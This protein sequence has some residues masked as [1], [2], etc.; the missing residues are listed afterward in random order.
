M[1]SYT[2]R[3]W[4]LGERAQDDLAIAV[5]HHASECEC[6]LCR[7]WLSL[8]ALGAQVPENPVTVE[9]KRGER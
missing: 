2:T 8:C 9:A 3:E 5:Q 1:R 7:A 4:E 6:A